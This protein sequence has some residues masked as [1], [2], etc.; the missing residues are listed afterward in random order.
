MGLPL[1]RQPSALAAGPPILGAPHFPGT[2][3][4]VLG[5]LFVLAKALVPRSGPRLPR[6]L[7]RAI[8]FQPLPVGGPPARNAIFQRADQDQ[9]DSQDLQDMASECLRI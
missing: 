1:A 2:F 6:P 8:R 4:G 9:Q 7:A 5:V 3:L